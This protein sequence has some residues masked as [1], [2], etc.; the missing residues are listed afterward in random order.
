MP[1]SLIKISFLLDSKC[2][3]LN[4]QWMCLDRSSPRT[5]LAGYF[6][7]GC[8]FFPIYLPPIGF[9]VLAVQGVDRRC[10]KL[11][12][13]LLWP[14]LFDW[15]WFW[16]SVYPNPGIVVWKHCYSLRT[17]INARW[18]KELHVWPF[19]PAYKV[20]NAWLYIQC[21]CGGALKWHH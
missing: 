4:C 10:N 14:F 15:S 20:I 17:D 13:F 5:I 12:L 7:Q 21:E 3:L 8:D 9:S 1:L 11:S 16:W 2:I 18:K 6:S 19:L